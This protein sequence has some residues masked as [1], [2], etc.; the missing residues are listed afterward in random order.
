MVFKKTFHPDFRQVVG[1]TAPKRY[2][3]FF[4]TNVLVQF[5]KHLSKKSQ[6]YFF[7][8]ICYQFERNIHVYIII[9]VT[10]C[11][12]FKVGPD[13]TLKKNAQLQIRHLTHICNDHLSEYL[14]YFGFRLVRLSRKKHFWV[15]DIPKLFVTCT[16]YAC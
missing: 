15:Q 9:F 13:M 6:S 2:T 11:V 10:F 7:F 1:D 16:A 12:G 4:R 5:S 14:R 3:Y 8:I